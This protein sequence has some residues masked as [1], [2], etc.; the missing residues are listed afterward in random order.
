MGLAVIS[1]IQGNVAACLLHERFDIHVNIFKRF[2]K[3]EIVRFNARGDVAKSSAGT[4][5][6]LHRYNRQEE[7]TQADFAGKG[8]VIN[9]WAT[10]C[11]ENLGAR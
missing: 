1:D 8:L 9:L 6:G 5:G 7:T 10:L 2:V 4:G 3:K 11:R